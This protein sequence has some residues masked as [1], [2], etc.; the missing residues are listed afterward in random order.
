MQWLESS[1][2]TQRKRDN[3]TAYLQEHQAGFQAVWVMYNAIVK[4]KDDIVN[5]FDSQGMAV[6]Q[7]IPGHGEGGEGYVLA[8]PEGDIKLVPREFFSKANRAVQR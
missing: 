4:I 6:K 7:S 3:L 1:K 8:H 2:L 5:K